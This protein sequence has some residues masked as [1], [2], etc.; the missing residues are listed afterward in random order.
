MSYYG[1]H[2]FSGKL[3]AEGFISTFENGL[4]D[5]IRTEFLNHR[6]V[7]DGAPAH[8]PFKTRR[9]LMINHIN[10]FKLLY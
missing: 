7:L 10:Q 8:T 2:M 6:I 9:Y 4:K 1:L 5:W 3:N